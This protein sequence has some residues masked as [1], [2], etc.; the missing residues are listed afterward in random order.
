MTDYGLHDAVRS[1]GTATAASGGEVG[2]GLKAVAAAIEKLALV[3]LAQ[4]TI[5]AYPN[6]GVDT[7][8]DAAKVMLDG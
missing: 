8:V 5:A 2:E 3:Q 7:A 1:L 6:W 4:T